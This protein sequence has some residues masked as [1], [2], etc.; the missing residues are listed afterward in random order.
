MTD[1]VELLPCPFCGCGD[2]ETRGHSAKY[3]RCKDCR[4]ES[5]A[6]ETIPKAIAAWNRRTVTK[7][8]QDA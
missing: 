3:I 6:H 1:T 4:A 8:T 2:I 7:E 5:G